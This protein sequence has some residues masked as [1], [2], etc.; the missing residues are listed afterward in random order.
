MALKRCKSD[1]SKG[2]RTFFPGSCKNQ[3]IQAGTGKEKREKE[4]VLKAMY[5]FYQGIKNLAANQDKIIENK[6]NILMEKY[7]EY[8]RNSEDEKIFYFKN[9]FING[10]T[11]IET[12]ISE[13]K[14][15]Q[16]PSGP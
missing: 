8:S 6:V 13:D 14:N 5:A 9:I 2:N 15:W 3:R 16:N 1:F 4:S 7:F 10:I 12:S 11:S